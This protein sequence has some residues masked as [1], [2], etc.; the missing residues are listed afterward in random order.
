M[1]VGAIDVLSDDLYSYSVMREFSGGTSKFVYWYL[2]DIFCIV[3]GKHL[4]DSLKLLNIQDK[5][6]LTSPW[7]L[8]IITT[9]LFWT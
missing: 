9:Y 2:D 4:D 5:K 7:R 6:T 3:K 8:K 1:L